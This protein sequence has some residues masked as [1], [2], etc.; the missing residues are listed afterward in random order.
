MM[1]WQPSPYTVTLLVSAAICAVIALLAWNRRAAPGA[2]PFGLAMTAVA[3]WMIGYTIRWAGADAATQF[4]GVKIVYLG[5][6]IEPSAFLVFAIQYTGRHSW[7]N[8]RNLGLLAVIPG[9][10]L[11]LI[12]TND[13][14]GLFWEKM[15]ME[16]A[17]GLSLLRWERG[18]WSAVNAIYSYILGVLAFLLLVQAFLRAPRLY[19][20]QASAV[21][22]GGVLFWVVALVNSINTSV[23]FQARLLNL[24]PWSTALFGF[25]ILYGI[26]GF[27]LFDIV[28]IARATVIEGLGDAVVVLD[29]QKRIVDVNPA[30]QSLFGLSTGKAIGRQ[31]GEVMAEWP[32]HFRPGEELAPTRTEI[33][34]ERAGRQKDFDVHI[35]PLAD[36]RGRTFGQAIVFREMTELKRTQSELL[37]QQ[38]A[39]A[40]LQERERLARELHDSLGQVLGYIILQLQA[41]RGF[42]AQ[43]KIETVDTQLT[44]LVQVSQ[45]A[46]AD[47]RDFIYSAKSSLAS[48]QALIPTLEQYIARFSRNY[49]IPVTLDAPE[50]EVRFPPATQ[51]HILRIVQEALNNVRKHAHARSAQVGIRQAAGWTEITV[52]DDGIGFDPETFPPGQGEHF[53]SRIMRERAEGIGSKLDLQSAPGKGTRLTL[54]IPRLPDGGT[55]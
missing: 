41:L 45:E 37:Q 53:G 8:R 21:L 42:A 6:A 33:S 35:S 10:T 36:R 24:T 51:A 43:G 25:S 12:W 32:A 14:H 28:P 20:A 5:I 22:F 17:N 4:I 44:R 2:L 29:A 47:V 11:L 50:A 1:S 15:W 54:S 9:I 7:L 46:Q 30:A 23:E 38:H 39:M 13:W 26:Q 18:V 31:I 52:A 27:R 48:G 3:L 40:I 34:L 55:Q 49:G 16:T 19:R